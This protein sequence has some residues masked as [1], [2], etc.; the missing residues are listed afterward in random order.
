MSKLRPLAVAVGTVII[1]AAAACSS[2]SS[3][4]GGAGSTGSNASSSSS[5]SVAKAVAEAA[6]K[7]KAAEQAP[8]TLPISTPLS[9]RPPTGET[10]VWLQCDAQACALQTTGYQA[11]ASALGWKLKVI[12]FQQADTSTLVSGL[13]QALQY[14]PLAVF[15]SGTVESEWSSVLPAYKAAGVAII[16]NDVGPTLQVTPPVV[17]QIGGVAANVYPGQLLADWM[18]ADSNATG[19]SLIVN[20]PAEPVLNQTASGI[21]SELKSLC[22]GC[23]YTTL[24]ASLTELSAGQIVPAIVSE[25]RRNP[26]IH[27]LLTTDGAFIEGIVPALKTAGIVGVKI[28][29]ARPNIVNETNVKAGT[30]AMTIGFADIPG[31]WLAVDAAAR[32]LLGMPIPSGEGN[33]PAQLFTSANLTTPEQTLYE[34]ANYAELFKKLWLVS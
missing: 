22:P 29:S 17:T 5:S 24:D 4:S 34:P 13:Q 15:L 9:R 21:T 10:V 3:S 33:L 6:A 28:A 7:V 23:K 30:E 19:N 27:Y 25:L 18:I 16:P 31:T 26:S 11:A 14:H 2:S 8:T 32:H 12:D 20:V 1:L